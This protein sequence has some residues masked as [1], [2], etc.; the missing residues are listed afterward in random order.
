M[1]IHH[2]ASGFVLDKKDIGEA[3]QLFTVFTEDFG[4]IEILGKAIRKIKSKLKA[5]IDFFYLSEIEFIQGKTYKTLTDAILIQKFSNLRKDLEKLEVAS[6]I[7]EVLD[8]LVVKEERDEKIWQLL[9]E[10]FNKLNNSSFSFIY[11][12]LL[13]NLLSVLGYEINLYNCAVCQRKLSP[14]KLYSNPKEGGIIDSD[15]YQKNKEGR[16]VLSEII[17]ILR[18]FLKRDWKILSKLKI[19]DN[20]KDQL[21][22]VSEEYFSNYKKH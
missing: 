3:D 2:R 13:W 17:K 12:Y 11:N 10:V 18:L 16:E 5:G 6:Q 1:A 9:N 22:L 7:V 8:N 19:D 20:Y 15:C 4:K 14:E 21:E